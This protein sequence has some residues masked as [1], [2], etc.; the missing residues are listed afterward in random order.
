MRTLTRDAT[1]EESSGT[2][3]AM[4]G[5]WTGGALAM[6]MTGAALLAACGSSGHGAGTTTST[7]ASASTTSG[8]TTTTSG[9]TG[10]PVP[11]GFSPVSFTAVSE[12][13]YWVLGSAPC[14]SGT[15][16]ALVRTVD[17]GAHFTGIPAP[18][19][20]LGAGGAPE[21]T[22]RFA[23]RLDG[24]AFVAL[25]PT[26]PSLFATHD[27]G[28]TWH[29]VGV[30]EVLSFA[31]GAGQAWVATA[32][33]EAGGCS[34]YRL[35]HSAL[36]GD[37]WAATPM[38][39]TPDGFSV[40]LEAHGTSMWLQGTPA[41]ASGPNDED[42]ARSTDGGSTFSVGRGPC[43]PGL[44]GRLAPVSATALWAVC[45]TGTRA[46]AWR[47]LDGGV[48][49]SPVAGLSLVNSAEIGAASATAA[50]IAPNDNTGALLRTTDGGSS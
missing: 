5:T 43:T 40:D 3:R 34:D 50:V 33:C 28:A 49:F 26:G 37:T 32:Q 6:T 21:P 22:L 44:G 14:P 46:G 16:P 42:L 10:G 8:P 35:Q 12:S 18:P 31:I 4:R 9:A 25:K 13:S 7:S 15:C 36:T 24:Y 45:P 1:R 29:A 20:P 30:G 48:T 2:V 41:S 39:F 47:S 11:A 17:G 23:D 38:P 27:G 19:V